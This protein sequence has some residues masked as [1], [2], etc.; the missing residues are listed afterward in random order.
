MKLNM[1]K[2]KENTA[3]GWLNGF[4]GVVLFSGSLPATRVAVSAFNPVFLTLARASIAGI[5]ALIALLIF[6]EKR[7]ERKQ[8]FP[9]VT[10]ALGVVIGFPL[11]AHWHYN[12]LRRLI[13]LFL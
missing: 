13:P 11:L 7:P 4:I 3:K 6:K 10:V 12:T 5:L 1:N 2:V 8:I 9:L